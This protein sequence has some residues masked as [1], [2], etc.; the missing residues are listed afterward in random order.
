MRAI[1]PGQQRQAPFAAQVRTSA[2]CSS[3]S[4]DHGYASPRNVLNKV[5]GPC[6]HTPDTLNF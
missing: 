2:S 6:T 1:S 4:D 5:Y 3:P